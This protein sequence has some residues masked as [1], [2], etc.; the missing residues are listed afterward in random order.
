MPVRDR[1]LAAIARGLLGRVRLDL[2]PAIETP[3][4]Q[5]HMRCS[6]VAECYRRAVVPAHRRR[7]PRPTLGAI[8]WA[9]AAA[10]ARAAAA[11]GRLHNRRTNR[12][13]GRVTF[14]STTPRKT[15]GPSHRY[16]GGRVGTESL[17][18]EDVSAV[19]VL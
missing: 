15:K 14:A 7:L 3:H 9:V 2:V 4:D 19:T 17:G 8:P 12:Q 10:M 16:T 13:Q 18:D 1:H 5:P 11:V 6:G